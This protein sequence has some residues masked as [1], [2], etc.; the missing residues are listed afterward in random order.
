MILVF[1]NYLLLLA[2][3]FAEACAHA[4][5]KIGKPNH[6]RMNW[7]KRLE[8]G[9]RNVLQ[10]TPNALHSWCWRA[11]SDLTITTVGF[12]FTYFVLKHT[13]IWYLNLPDMRSCD[14]LFLLHRRF[15]HVSAMILCTSWWLFPTWNAAFHAILNGFERT[16]LFRNMLAKKKNW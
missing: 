12:F 5:L 8:W 16:W 4:P 7:K 13:F 10:F 11:P 3:K 14:S 15:F 2:T 1:L 9:G 6:V